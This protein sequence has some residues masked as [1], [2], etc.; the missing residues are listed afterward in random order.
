[1]YSYSDPSR[2]HTKLRQ[3]I[4]SAVEVAKQAQR[5]AAM[6]AA[7]ELAKEIAKNNPPEEP[8]KGEGISLDSEISMAVSRRDSLQKQLNELEGRHNV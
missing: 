3:Q 6:K 5:E 8:L 1:M 2:A 7:D 4:S